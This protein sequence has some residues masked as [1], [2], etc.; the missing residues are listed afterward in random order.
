[1]KTSTVPKKIFTQKGQGLVEYALLFGFVA[2]VA[3]IVFAKGGFGQSM[4]NTYDVAGAKTLLR[5]ATV[6][7]IQ[8]TRKF[9]LTLKR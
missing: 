1:M 6:F 4:S 8:T 9:P 5:R 3:L 2:A 7:L